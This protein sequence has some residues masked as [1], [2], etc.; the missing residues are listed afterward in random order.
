MNTKFLTSPA[1]DGYFMPAEFSEHEATILIWPERPGSWK[2]NAVQAQRDFAGIAEILLASERVFVLA[3]PGSEKAARSKLPGGA[4]VLV[5]P[6]DDAWARDTAPTFVKNKTGDVRGVSWSFNAWGGTFDGLYG[7]W[8]RDNALAG[9]FCKAA[10]YEMYD[11]AP[12]VLEGGSI[13]SDGEG[14]LLT[15]ECCLLSKGRNPHMTKAEIEEK[16][17]DYTGATKIFWLPEGIFND[18]TNGHVD[19][20]SCFTKP[21]EA[22]L[23]WTDNENDPQH[24]LSSACL[25]AFESTTDTKGRSI[26]VHKLPIPEYPVTITEE[27][28]KGFVF[29]PGEDMREVGERLAASYVNFYFA[30]KA[31]LVPQFG[32]KNA[33]SDKEAL[34]ILK[35]LCPDREVIGVYARDIL[36]GGGNIHCIT[37]QIPKFG[38]R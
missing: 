5:I 36:C 14:T 11:A 27:D 7:N 30:N 35:R 29:E 1:K 19:N 18:E 9:A 12:F 23:A 8:K 22:V 38:K 16:L 17:C 6:S 37:Q 21:G 24:S 13:H 33:D 31:V 20:I 32:G 26:K 15:T 28:M 10:D 3:N 4:E 25:K 2:N 34:N